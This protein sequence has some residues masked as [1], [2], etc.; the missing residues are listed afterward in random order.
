M[1]ALRKIFIIISY[2]LKENA[3]KICSFNNRVNIL[4]LD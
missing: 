4:Q 1:L 2:I 3:F